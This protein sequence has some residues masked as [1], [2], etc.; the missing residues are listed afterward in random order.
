MPG[1]LRLDPQLSPE[2]DFV[3]LGE[4][5]AAGF[6]NLSVS[7]DSQKTSFPA[8]MAAQMGVDFVQTLIQPPGIG[9]TIGFP[10]SQVVL[11]S[12]LQSTV[13][14]K[15]PPDPP[16]NL[17][18]PG[19]SVSDAVTLRPREPLIDR[20]CH[21]QTALNLLLGAHY[22]YHGIQ[23]E[24]PTP[25]EMALQRKPKLALVELGY[26][27]ALRAATAGEATLLPKDETFEKDYSTIV[28]CL[29]GAGSRVIALSIPDPL[30]TAYFNTVAEAAAVARIEAE[31]LRELWNV[32][33]D[34]LITVH[35]LMEIGFQILGAVTG[36][37]SI[38]YMSG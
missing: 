25:L 1:K 18:V 8:F 14:E 26:A 34:A 36:S 5:L 28:S 9:E 7:S 15:M 16:S 20:D 2:F 37:S 12:P 10:V 38:L 11:P 21:G 24:V 17:S 4:S 32:P 27:E 6:G 35:G 29:R 22:I 30:D 23:G 19:M 13:V 3:V 31:L 33:A